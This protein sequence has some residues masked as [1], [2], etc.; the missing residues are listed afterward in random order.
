MSSKDNSKRVNAKGKGKKKETSKDTK[1]S[2]NKYHYKK[3][4]FTENDIQDMIKS[5]RIKNRKEFYDVNKN[6][7]APL[8]LYTIQDL[9]DGTFLNDVV[10]YHF[11]IPTSPPLP[12]PG[13]DEYFDK[14]KR[15]YTFT[16]AEDKQS[17]KLTKIDNKTEYIDNHDY[18]LCI[19]NNNDIYELLKKEI[20]LKVNLIQFLNANKGSFPPLK[21]VNYYDIKSGEF[22]NILKQ[23]NVQIPKFIPRDDYYY[24]D[25]PP[26]EKDIHQ[27]KIYEIWDYEEYYKDLYKVSFFNNDYEDF[28]L[29]KDDIIKDFLKYKKEYEYK[30]YNNSYIIAQKL[31]ENP[32]EIYMNNLTITDY[33]YHANTIEYY[34]IKNIIPKIKRRNY[35]FSLA[36]NDH[37][38]EFPDLNYYTY[39]DII[40]GIFIKEKD[41]YKFKWKTIAPILSK[42]DK[43]DSKFP[44]FSDLTDIE[45]IWK[46]NLLLFNY[47]KLNND[48]IY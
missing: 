9:E 10:E 2:Q 48:H 22:E 13:D 39:N 27:Y 12:E 21:L 35:N 24:I 23:Y 46:I 28:I 18:Y 43:N 44:D 4:R 7:M 41:K 33:Y 26:S 6:T 29:D 34:T 8:S 14:I 1:K 37:Y 40:H 15:I 16:I 20:Q 11:E 30:L 32:K 36:N 17:I 3:D 19:L 42:Y 25:I 47:S 38:V 45:E 31:F 5:N